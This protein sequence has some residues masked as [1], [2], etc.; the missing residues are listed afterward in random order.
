M[1]N[2]KYMNGLNLQNGDVVRISNAFQKCDNGLYV[3]MHCPGDVNWCG[4]DYSLEKI[5][6]NGE[7]ST[8]KYSMQ[9]LPLSYT[10]NNEM[11][12][13]QA[14]EWDDEN[15][16]VEVVENINK[17]HIIE[18]FREEAHKADKQ[19][20]FYEDRGY[21]WEKW[22]KQYS[23]TRDFYLSIV[24][25]LTAPQEQ[26]AEIEPERIEENDT[27]QPEQAEKESASFERVYYPINENLAR[28]AQEI[29]SFYEYKAGSATETYK[30]H[31]DEVYSIAEQIA[32]EKHEQASTAKGKA[33]YFA[34]K[35]A[36]YYNDYYRNEASCPSVMICGAGN[37]PVRKKQK[38]NS[39]RETL[40][41]QYKYLMDYKRKIK[42]I[43][44]C[45]QPIKAG[46][47]T[48]TEQIKAKIEKL[49]ANQDKMKKVNAYFR[50]FGNLDGCELL[51]DDEKETIL[52]S[53]GFSIYHAPFA[54][55]A[56]SNNT[57]E[58]RR[59]KSRLESLE[60][61]KDAGTKEDENELFRIVENTE[62]M[63]LQLFF[64]GVPDAETRDILKSNGFRWAPSCKA[65][66]R[67]LTSNA[68]Y[69]LQQVKKQLNIA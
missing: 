21:D 12:C 38:Q 14:R 44:T 35:L 42:N 69:S 63:R 26:E 3:V 53:F 13:A 33:L 49:E 11:R 20:E 22:C 27:V 41:N 23:N 31:C 1:R 58:I 46:D 6:R 60:K 30:S 37:F 50:K 48:A 54:G 32:Q 7:I 28:V 8:A 17:E 10:S 59:L 57:A 65:W 39:R 34:A 47:A 68:K 19:R 24:E 2:I 40:N 56:L 4:N 29:N 9:F 55:Y 52:K 51:T 16:I 25:R 61:V 64:D 18:Y 15:L 67:Q 36:T 45:D 43:L 5:K 62:N 66:Q